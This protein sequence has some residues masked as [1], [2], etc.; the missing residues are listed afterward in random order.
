MAT[1]AGDT[2]RDVVTGRPK[3]FGEFY[4]TGLLAY[5]DDPVAAAAVVQAAISKGLS[6]DQF[7]AACSGVKLG[8]AVNR[9]GGKTVADVLA[10]VNAT[11]AGVGNAV[12]P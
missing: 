1:V 11:V 9:P 12:K 2:A 6:G 4:A 3:R 10:A 7:A 5:H 8:S